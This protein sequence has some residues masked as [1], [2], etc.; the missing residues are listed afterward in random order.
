MVDHTVIHEAVGTLDAL[1]RE[2]SS[3]SRTQWLQLARDCQVLVNRLTAVQDVAIA[4]AASIESVW[5]EDGTLDE[6]DRGRGRIAL[7]A[8]DV[9][10]PVIGASHHQA[11][12]RV[13]QAVRLTAGREP[14]PTDGDTRPEP[15]GLS[16]VHRAMRAGLL[17]AYRASVV[18]FEL[19]GCPADVAD[20]VVTALGDHLGSEP[21]PDLRRRTRRL[22][23]RISPDLLRQRAE[24]A[25]KDTGLRRWVAEPGVDEWH[26]TFPSEDSATAWAAIDRLARRYVLDG[27]CP[28]LEKARAKALTDLVLEH[29]D[30]RVQV[31]LTVPADAVDSGGA[32]PTDAVDGGPSA[33]DGRDAREQGPRLPSPSSTTST[34][35]VLV[36]GA[37]PSEPLLVPAAWLARHTVEI[38][39]AVACHPAT[40]A[41]VDPDEELTTAAYRPGRKLTGLVTQRDGGCR[42]PGCSVAARFCDLD[43]VRPWP[44]GPTAASNLLCLCR[45]HHRIK[46]SAGWSLR[47]RPDGIAEWTDPTGRRRTSRPV[48]ALESVT[49]PPTDPEPDPPPPE[50]ASRPDVPS[51]LEELLAHRLDQH[52]AMWRHARHL[53]VT[54]GPRYSDEPPF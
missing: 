34:E 50:A 32:V 45:R 18:V 33:G 17:D 25:R 44:A 22:L 11:Q 53:T 6:V 29:S 23:A 31:V 4:H 16:G 40:G 41:R 42:F 24:R 9:V 8:A 52:E 54:V 48:D 13:E 12:H 20:T 28:D 37:R 10:A 3:R 21:A 51:I 2:P 38:A 26:G 14:V 7:D 15:N 43:H 49:L 47:L 19:V 27:I 30:V 35:L 46:Q 5:T 39:E 36:R 1:S